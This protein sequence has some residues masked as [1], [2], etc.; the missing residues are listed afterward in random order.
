MSHPLP[1]LRTSRLLLAA[2]QPEQALTLARL[3]DEPTIAAMTAALPSPYTL[4]HAQAFIAETHDQYASGQ[5]VSLGV[6]IQATGEL[7]G[8]VSLRL[9]MSHRSGNLGYW[10][11]LQYQNRG[12]ACE[13]AKGLL[14]HGFTEMNLNRIAGQ[15]F[16]DNPA[17]ARVLEKCGLS[18]EGCTREAFLKNGVFKN[19]LLFSLLRSEY[20]PSE[21]TS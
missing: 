13:A 9:S 12:Y 16:S 11:G 8:I 17:S 15:C 3:A 14:R 1:T 20:E 5:T 6:H 10:T 2:L 19:M 21:A 4:E 7:T 18:Y